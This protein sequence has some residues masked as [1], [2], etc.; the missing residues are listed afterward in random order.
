MKTPL[1]SFCHSYY[2]LGGK[3]GSTFTTI[4]GKAQFKRLR[5]NQL[6]N[7]EIK[8]RVRGAGGGFVAA[9][10]V[11]ELRRVSDMPLEFLKA[12][13]EY[14]GF[15][16]TSHQG[17]VDLLN[18]FRAPHW[19]QVDLNSELTIITLCKLTQCSFGAATPD[20]CQNTI[21]HASTFNGVYTGMCWCD[22]HATDHAQGLVTPGHTSIR[23]VDVNL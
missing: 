6:A 1:I 5:V 7:V 23:F 13:A 16:L 20:R 3:S 9:I 19:T 21:T 15:T 11:L 10:M 4:R 17:F 14:P 2:K 22:E 8:S 18:S 12:D